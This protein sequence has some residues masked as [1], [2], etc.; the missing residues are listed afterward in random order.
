MIRIFA[1][2]T[3]TGVLLF[4]LQSGCTSVQP[5]NERSTPLLNPGKEQI[6]K[7]TRMSDPNSVVGGLE[8]VPVYS[9]VFHRSGDIEL[10]LTATL[11][12][13]NINL[14]EEI[15]ITEVIYCNT[16]GNWISK[17]VDDKITLKPL[18]T[19]Q[20]VI[21]EIDRSGGTGANFL[22]KWEASQNVSQPLIE[23]L[24]IST[25]SQQG[26]SFVCKGETILKLKSYEDVEIK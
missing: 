14:F 5:E 8:F 17:Y 11:S 12:I 18:A 3:I 13:H 1:M 2:L 15:L 26:L 7:L 16:N 10:L 23:S 4:L 20:F 19:K 24:M 21:P 22:V 9:S 25:T 6:Q